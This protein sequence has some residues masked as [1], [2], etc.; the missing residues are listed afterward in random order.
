MAEKDKIVE[1]KVKH[2][3]IFDFREVYSFIYTLLS[4]MEY[5]VEEKNYGEK[6]KGDQKELEVNWLAKRKISDYFRFII[7]ID[8]RVF[9]MTSADVVKDGVKTS[10]NKGDFEV[11]FTAYLEKDYENR[12]ENTAFVKFLRGLYERY[13]I[14]GAIN[15]YS[16]QLEEEANSL[17]NQTKALLDLSGR[18]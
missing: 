6:T 10:V 17:A 3:G 1:M 11:K 5:S 9:R 18:K 12:W 15:T 13:I 8:L 2:S 16:G 14:Q 7:K 4:D